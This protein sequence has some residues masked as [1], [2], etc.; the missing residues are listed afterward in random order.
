MDISEEQKIKVLNELI[1]NI[2]NE[3]EENQQKDYEI[4]VKEFAERTGLS[5]E[6]SRTKLNRLVKSG[7]MKQ[8]YIRGINGKTSVYSVI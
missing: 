2:K 4:S 7:Q 3:L 6:N 1:A 8:R 5:I